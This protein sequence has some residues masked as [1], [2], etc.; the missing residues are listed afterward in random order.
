T[1]GVVYKA[2]DRTTDEY[3]ALKRMRMEAWS[4]G[5]PAT[6]MREISVLK[7]VAHPN[8]VQC[9]PWCTK[10]L[11]TLNPPNCDLAY[12]YQLVNG[13]DAC[14][15]HRTIHRDIKPQNILLN[16]DGWLKL[17]DFGLARTFSVPLRRY[18]H[19]VVTLWYR[20]PE[21]LLGLER[22]SAAVD[23]W[24]IGCIF[25]EMAAGRPLFMGD[26]E[27][28]QLFKIFRLLGTPTEVTWPGVSKL[29]DFQGSFPRW[30]AKG[31]GAAFDK[32]GPDGVDL[33][34]KLLT[35]DPSQRITTAEALIHPY[36]TNHLP[37][38]N[39]G[40]ITQAPEFLSGVVAAACAT[41]VVVP[42]QKS[43]KRPA[44]TVP[45]VP[46]DGAA[47]G[48]E[49]T[50]PTLAAAQLHSQPASQGGHVA[51]SRAGHSKAPRRGE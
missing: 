17:A 1:Y 4:E 27:I 22:Y 34:T 38:M 35:Y 25:A 7:E 37:N 10:Y 51:A 24:S 43:K 29:K 26:S 46:T 5:V 50:V 49:N 20:A 6:A 42:P 32:L 16:D 8:V 40:V 14:H 2:H 11:A 48:A 28:D 9:V 41:G 36:F 45:A 33:L 44:S 3:V 39:K 19:E 12:M 13:V 47:G 23:S 31:F 21:I 18:T 15:R 30:P